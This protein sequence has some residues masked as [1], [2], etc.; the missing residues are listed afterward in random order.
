MIT[1]TVLG[2]WQLP[3]PSDSYDVIMRGDNV[4]QFL[5][6]VAG[7][8][9]TRSTFERNGD[10]MTVT[11]TWQIPEYHL[12]IR[13]AI[14]RDLA[15]GAAGVL[16]ALLQTTPKWMPPRKLVVSA[17]AGNRT[18][19]EQYDETENGAPATYAADLIATLNQ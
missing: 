11:W 14:Y 9:P 8:A 19:I 10:L 2:V 15:R 5:F 3:S 6:G 18:E 13:Q 17:S 1:T 16:A 12:G 7:P 4:A